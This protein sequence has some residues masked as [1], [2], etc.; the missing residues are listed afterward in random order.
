[1]EKQSEESDIVI[2]PMTIRHLPDVF[3]L[4]HKAF[5]TEV[6]PYTSW[7]LSAAAVHIDAARPACFVALRGSE[8]C[9]FVLGSMTFEQRADWGYLEWIAVDSAVRGRGVAG[10]LV[11]VCRDHLMAQG[12]DAVITDVEARNEASL[13]LMRRH[14]FTVGATVNLLAY[15]RE[16]AV[17]RPPPLDAGS[18][19]DAPHSEQ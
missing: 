10:R 19:G 17:E 16:A 1:M 9:G 12:A 13:A 11:A 3:D 8:L 6:K 5:D 7:S 18:N 15:A 4:G 2:A 14:G